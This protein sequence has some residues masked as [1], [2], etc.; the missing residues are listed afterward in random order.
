MLHHLI[1]INYAT[2][3]L[4][5]ML[6]IFIVTNRYFDKRIRRLFITA[7]IVMITIVVADSVEYWTASF[8]YPTVLRIWMSA[9]GYS[10]RPA[11]ILLIIILFFQKK[12]NNWLMLA[13]PLAVNALLAFSAMFTDIAYSYSETNEFVR[14][15]LGIFAYVTS[16]W[17][18]IVLLVFTIRSYKA[19]AL[20]ETMIS[21]V[22]VCVFVLATVLEV[23]FLYDGLI[24]VTGAIAILFYYLYLNTQQFKRDE[25]TGALNRR[26]FNLDAER[27]I[28][29][30]SAVI[31]IDLNGL[32]Q[33]NDTQGHAKGDEA[34]ST[35]AS[36]V[37][38]S[39]P[40]GCYL[41]RVGGDEFMVLCFK[42]KKDLIEKTVA[43][44]RKRM[45]KTPFACAIGT[46]YVEGMQYAF[47]KWV[48]LADAAMYKEKDKMKK[49]EKIRHE[50][51][52]H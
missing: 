39:L 16:A 35:V 8:A 17:Y 25:L 30:L 15:P 9:L 23:G 4:L 1:Q 37:Q 32:K 6:L 21:V 38:V 20:T 51:S 24:N 45:D 7:S 13:I 29:K 11:A 31:S 47:E 33:I 28:G 48:E 41:Y 34:I 12:K 52:I 42:K 19:V 46:V 5:S 27:N 26:C 44:I 43:D 14:G 18:F 10:L 49:T 22:V 3:I 36:C 40:R 2:V 50:E